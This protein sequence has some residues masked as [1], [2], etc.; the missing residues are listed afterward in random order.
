MIRVQGSD[1]DILRELSRAGVD[2]SPGEARRIK[3]LLGRD[4]TVT[5]AYI[6]DI[7]WSE[8]CSYKSSKTVLARYLP[9]E[10]RDV[11]IGPGEDAGVVRLGRSGDETYVLVV[12]HE[13]HNHPSQ[14]LPVEGAATGIGGIVRDVYCMGADVVGVM[15]AL[16]FGDP[17]GPD[18]ERVK[19]IFGG[20]VRGIWEYGNALGVPN[21]GGDVFFDSGY[22]ENCLVNVI[23]FGVAREE[24]IIRSRVPE[25]AGSRPYDIIIVGKPTDMSGLGGATMASRILDD[26]SRGDLGAVQIHDPFLKRVLTEAT[27]VVLRE[28]R[29]EGH[30]I[31]FKDLGAGGIS[32]AV[33]EVAG[34]AGFGARLDLDRVHTAFDSIE[35]YAVA[36][37]ETQERYC[38]VVPAEFSRRVLEIYN[39][40]FELPH[41]Y[42]GARASLAGKVTAEKT[43]EM[44]RG[45]RVVAHL[46]LDVVN[47]GICYQR[48]ASPRPA[49]RR[50]GKPLRLEDPT[51]EILGVIGLLSNCSKQ[52]I[53]R[54]YDTE[55]KGQSVLK[56]G[57]ADACVVQ[58]EGTSLGIACSVDGNPRYCR[59]DPYSGGVLAVAESVRNLAAVGARPLALTDCLNFGNPEVP[60]IFHDFTETVRGI[61]HAARVL[62]PGG[63]DEPIPVVSGNVSFY[64]ESSSGAAIPPSP[65]VACYGVLEDYSVALGLG[66]REAESDLVLVGRRMAG[67]GGSALAAFLGRDGGSLFKI[68][69]AGERKA[70]AAATEIIRYGLALACH[71]IAEGGLVTT[72]VEMMLGGRGRGEL[73]VEVGAEFDP[74]LG[75]AEVL[76]GECGGF[77]LEVRPESTA[78]VLAACKRHG[79]WA[80]TVGKTIPESRLVIAAGAPGLIEL[81]G[82]QL[83]RA[84][85]G[86]LEE[87]VR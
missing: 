10:G 14:I 50:G 7:M 80:R 12:A 5:E 59:S 4:P 18:S 30:R 37:S 32:C 53:Y 84:W 24:E 41:I 25:E 38:L 35:A 15:D 23:A 74:E 22:D 33:S 85:L 26:S 67:L 68:D 56:P 73:G 20:V 57:E 31:G 55:V 83:R 70:C 49:G 61:G 48:R 28:A 52:Y 43:L 60:E 66:L 78:A 65:I 72:L 82:E 81:E 62:G 71:D 21:T 45:D 34:S 11:I 36:C 46:P 9:T 51:R 1:E 27:K 13:S 44:V 63:K 17:F 6:F 8:H 75:A 47:E 29:E 79:A 69:L 19:E 40:E 39:E 58:V 16:R 64:N 2:I 86:P 77:V 3:E 54:H 87:A 42:R 76:F